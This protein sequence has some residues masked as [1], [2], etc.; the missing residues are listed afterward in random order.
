VL[1]PARTPR[2]SLST[3]YALPPVYAFIEAI[4]S[5][6]AWK[7]ANPSSRLRMIVYT[8]QPDVWLNLTSGRI[9]IE[10]L[11][12]SNL[13]HF[14]AVIQTD[15][16]REPARRVLYYPRDELLG[17]VLEDL[18]ILRTQRWGLSIC[19]SPRRADQDSSQPV[20]RTI[21]SPSPYLTP[22]RHY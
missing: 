8:V 1:G 17:T 11:L 5:F 9:N 2:G 7:R 6:G 14:W 20:E 13:M 12:T 4:R 22:D 3:V 18:R 21:G 15:E 16:K 10:E 19:P